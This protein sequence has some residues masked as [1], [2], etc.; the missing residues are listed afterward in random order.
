MTK[1]LFF[2]AKRYLH[3]VA[4][5]ALTGVALLSATAL[6]AQDTTTA[7]TT[8]ANADRGHGRHWQHHHGGGPGGEMGF[9][10]GKAKTKLGLTD[11]QTQQ[12]RT[13]FQNA[14][15]Q[16]RPL[17]ERL[18]TEHQALRTLTQAATVDEP[19]IRAQA[20]KV[21]AVEADLAVQ[22]AQVAQQVR[23]ILTP[24]QIQQVQDWQ[25]KRAARRAQRHAPD[26]AATPAG[27]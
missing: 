8:D 5:T 25:A 23:A 4:T 10:L 11:A 14:R 18:R 19:A 15:P 16:F 12:I 3:I 6:R 22:R 9:W 20:A 2:T 26:A 21:A 17:M 7:T 24:E 13:V 27:S 1:L